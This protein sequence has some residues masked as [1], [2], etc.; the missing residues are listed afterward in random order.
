MN[1][2]KEIQPWRYFGVSTA[3]FCLILPKTALFSGVDGALGILL[4]TMVMCV[5]HRMGCRLRSVV[6]KNA[7]G[8]WRKP[9][10]FARIIV[11]GAVL[12]ALTGL[13]ACL[14][15]DCFWPG[16]S[17]G[18]AWGLFLLLLLPAL[19]KKHSV[20]Q[21][22]TAVSFGWLALLV[23]GMLLL[24]LGQVQSTWIAS[25]LTPDPVRVVAAA[26][27][28]LMLSWYLVLIPGTK[29]QGMWPDSKEGLYL[30]NGIFLAALCMI[31]GFVYGENG[32]L[33]RRWPVLS[34][35]Q[36]IR[37]PGKFL[38]RV[39]AL[40]AAACLFALF[41]AAGLLVERLFLSLKILGVPTGT[42]R[43]WRYKDLAALALLAAVALIYGYSGVE[44][45]NRAYV[46]TFIADREGD[47]YVFWFPQQEIEE[48]VYA[49]HADSFGEA[50]ELLH[51]NSRQQ[52][53]FG[54]I[55]A[56]ILGEGLLEDARMTAS[57]F[58]ELAAWQDMDENSYVFCCSD[59]GALM[60]ADTEGEPCGV[61]LAE[62]YENHF[63]PEE[64]HPVLRNLLVN[65]ENGNRRTDIPRIKTEGTAVTVDLAG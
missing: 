65:W 28:Y 5:L 43:M 31:L 7:P 52:P 55:R 48:T 22:I 12:A 35:L 46:S 11:Y 45:Q 18:M 62:L 20:W 57:L 50:L 24:S 27:I 30:L 9:A 37:V 41:L 58:E 15:R 34:L 14:L 13:S 21:R 3:F 61:Y 64:N 51:R 10:A 2:K 49:V 17:L 6:K 1:R 8:I 4:A 63:G 40:W 44:A 33:S 23:T 54:H 16:M 47:S 56:T 26:V 36:G 39:D 32:V 53:D 42:V 38:E 25:A 60:A 19:G 29:S 59:P